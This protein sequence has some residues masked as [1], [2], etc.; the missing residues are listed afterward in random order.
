MGGPGG[1][2]ARALNLAPTTSAITTRDSSGTVNSVG[3]GPGVSGPAP[4]FRRTVEHMINSRADD[5]SKVSP[6]IR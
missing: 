4:L 3:P 5:C 1:V 2:P 6:G